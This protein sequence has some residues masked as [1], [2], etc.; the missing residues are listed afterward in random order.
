M[1]EPD[2]AHPSPVFPFLTDSSTLDNF[3]SANASRRAF[4][5]DGSCTEKSKTAALAW[6]WEFIQDKKLTP[7]NADA[8]EIMG[9]GIS[10]F[11]ACEAASIILREPPQELSKCAFYSAGV[12]G[13]Y[14]D[15]IAEFCNNA[16]DKS[17]D[18]AEVIYSLA[19]KVVKLVFNIMLGSPPVAQNLFASRTACVKLAT[20]FDV[21]TLE[22]SAIMT[23]L[24]CPFV[25]RLISTAP[26]LSASKEFVSNKF[27]QN[28]LRMLESTVL[29]YNTSREKYDNLAL[30]LI[31]LLFA[32]FLFRT[33]QV[34][35]DDQ[36]VLLFAGGDGGLL[37]SK[38]CQIL[39]RI[40]DSPDRSDNSL[41]LRTASTTVLFA[42]LDSSNKI[43]VIDNPTTVLAALHTI[44]FVRSVIRLAE[45]WIV[46]YVIEKQPK[47]KMDA[48][49]LPSVLILLYLCNQD[50]GEEECRHHNEAENHRA[51]EVT[52]VLSHIFLRISLN[53]FLKRC[54]VALMNPV[55]STPRVAT[56][57]GELVWAC[58]GK[59]GKSLV[60][61]V[62]AG[63]AAQLLI[64]KGLVKVPGL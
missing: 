8:S 26:T 6:L 19:G 45:Q 16:K 59:D 64:Q 24:I 55:S 35:H 54:I 41:R 30:R 46:H 62:G 50:I 36:T 9:N 28:I 12:L 23:S 5:K 1:A 37:L 7:S 51:A 4:V 22:A 13:S 27:V 29:V 47:A 3:V 39:V 20:L 49:L 40:L 10:F 56:A 2:T 17:K 32:I 63:A 61:F 48:T 58:C 53:D 18:D 15:I 42:V 34:A 60:K 21:S 43:V 11:S 52:D 31:N 44:A 57:V 14:L 38:M 33:K 25:E